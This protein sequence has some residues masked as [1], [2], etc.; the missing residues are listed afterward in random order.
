MAAWI[1]AILCLGWICW[2]TPLAAAADLS[3]SPPRWQNLGKGLSFALMDVLRDDDVAGALAVVKIDPGANAFRIFHHKPQKI[4]AWQQEIQAQVVFNASFYGTDGKPVGLVVSDGKLVGPLK[5][6]QMRGM[7]VAEPKGVSPDLP[8]ATILDLVVSPIQP[9]KLPWT[10]GVQS[11]P[12]LLDSKGRIRVHPSDKAAHRTVIATD[13]SGNIL[14]FNTHS[15]SLTLYDLARLLKN[16]E[17]E[18]DAALNLDGGT[19]AQLYIKTKDFEFFSPPAWET[20]LGSLI[21]RKAFELPTVVGV[22]P[23]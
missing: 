22:F 6:P 21:D 1:L 5:N 2:G 16:S 18:V 13:H 4:T 8:R 11:F 10:Q 3:H 20:Q 19:E 15:G 23:R 14:V 12:L 7:F 17:L 9:H